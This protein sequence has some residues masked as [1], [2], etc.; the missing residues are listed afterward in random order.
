MKRSISLL[1]AALLLASVS[2]G[3]SGTASGSDTTAADTTTAAPVD[4][5]R[6]GE[7]GEQDFGGKTF[8]ILDANDY[9][10]MH[11]NMPG[12]EM[13]GD[14]I[15]DALFERDGKIEDLFNVDIKYEQ[16][17]NA[18]N[19]I[20]TLRS[21]ELAG[22][23][24][25]NL[26]ISTVCGGRLA[27]LATEGILANLCAIPN[28]T[29]DA[30]WWSR[31]MYE[32][33]RLGD[34]MYFTTG[35]ISPTVYQTPG[36]IYLNQKLLVDYQIDTDFYQLVRDGKWTV[37]ELLNVTR[38]AAIDVNQDG[39]MKV[40]DD[41]FGMI[42]LTNAVTSSIML[43]GCGESLLAN[44]GQNLSVALNSER[45]AD[46]VE[47]I[48]EVSEPVSYSKQSTV[49][50]LT[51][52][53]DKAIAGVN[54]VEIAITDLRDME[55]DYLVLPMPK[56]DEAQEG[57]RSMLNGWA[58]CFVAVP[59]GAEAEFTGF[60]TEALAYESYASVRPKVYDL[61]LKQK[62]ARDEGSAEMLDIIFNTT[63]LDFMGIYEFASLPTGMANVLFKDRPLA[64][65]LASYQTKAETA[66]ASFVEN[67][68]QE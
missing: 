30:N 5:S 47:K 24:I 32:N 11:I 8:T 25:Y 37:D 58:D 44:D 33:C 13:N 38:D 56:F 54:C 20:N 61:V 60:I 67:W 17:T 23:G 27:T 7:L 45:L 36:C 34:K 57:Y 43:V 9:P 65:T 66:I 4:T 10:D 39:A 18:T 53:V 14:I 40:G 12:D 55:S 64:S 29:L 63:Y 48:R 46:V 3:D 21:S 35:D 49:F 26:C 68:I 28:L 50:D 59:K 42:Y 62:G 6:L 1:L 52:K 16:I 41:F 51:F 15:N 31:L 22:D 19:G 2:C